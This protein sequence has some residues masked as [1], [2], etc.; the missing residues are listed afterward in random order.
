LPSSKGWNQ[1]SKKKRQ[2]RKGF[3]FNPNLDTIVLE[4]FDYTDGWEEYPVGSPLTE[5]ATFAAEDEVAKF[6]DYGS[7]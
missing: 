4:T 5:L 2:E 3:R 6:N 7:T 1:T